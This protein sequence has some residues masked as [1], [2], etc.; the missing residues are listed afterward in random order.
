MEYT[1]V[2]TD[3]Y[4][5]VDEEISRVANS[6]YAD[7]GTPLYDGI[8][9][10]SK[11]KDEIAR[12]QADSINTIVRVLYDLVTIKPSDAAGN[13]VLS[14]YVP[15][16]DVTTEPIIAEELNRFVV[17]TICY[18]WL[19]SHAADKAED[20]STRANDAISK[21]SAMLHTRKAPTR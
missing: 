9:L 12:L 5:L 19:R 15:D 1:I 17:M 14:F 2:N 4:N 20:Y 11:D 8:V 7:D 13:P 3:I 10:H 6:A 21:A 18:R 16:I